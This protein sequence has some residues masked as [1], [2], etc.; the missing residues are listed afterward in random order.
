[1]QRAI[2]DDQKVYDEEGNGAY[3]DNQP[4]QDT[5]EDPFAVESPAEEPEEIDITE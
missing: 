3:L 4:D 5:E 1:M 2:Q